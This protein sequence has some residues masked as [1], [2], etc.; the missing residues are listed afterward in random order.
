MTKNKVEEDVKTLEVGTGPSPNLSNDDDVDDGGDYIRTGA[1][2]TV[3][4]ELSSDLTPKRRTS[5]KDSVSRLFLLCF[6]PNLSL[7]ES[8]SESVVSRVLDS[9][10]SG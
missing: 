7:Q 9:S 10:S 6:C 4:I 2:K 3:A 8:H 1:Q 5:G